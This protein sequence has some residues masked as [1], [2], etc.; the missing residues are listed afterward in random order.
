MRTH[1]RR[2]SRGFVL[3]TLIASAAAVLTIVGLAIDTGHLHL[4]K[5]RMQTAA[6]AGALGAVLER[7]ADSRAD[8]TA[9]AR[10]DA[11]ANGFI[12][13]QDS[14]TVGVNSPPASGYY[15]ADPTAV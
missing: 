12:H 8:V 4:V 13:G 1:R 15:A 5:M 10:A 6:D 2:R 11:A 7:R 3:V 9:P 14:V